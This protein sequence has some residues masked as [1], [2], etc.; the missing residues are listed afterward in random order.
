MMIYT[1]TEAGNGHA[2]EDAIAH[3]PHPATDKF[4][5]CAL[6][7]GQGGRSGGGIAAQAA[8]L[9]TLDAACEVKPEALLSP[10]RWLDVCSAADR[11]VAAESDTGYCTL[12]ALVAA[13]EWIVGASSGDSAAALILEHSAVILTERQ[14]KN[15]PVGSGAAKFETFSARPGMR[16][17]VLVVSDG[18]W[19][20]VGWERMITVGRNAQGN[21]IA[22]ALRREVLQSHGL[23]PDDFSVIVIES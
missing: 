23:L 19:K 9:L 13:D 18:V 1:F 7:D 14:H 11:G 16:W 2:N 5:L 8:V 21:Q 12:V 15:P 10:L 22:D 3:R 6:A 4:A 20:Y 17:R